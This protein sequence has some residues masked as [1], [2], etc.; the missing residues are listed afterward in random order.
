MLAQIKLSCGIARNAW[1]KKHPFLL[2]LKPTARCNLRCKSCNRWQ[3]D[4]SIHEELS[5][6]AIQEILAKFKKAGF[7]VFTLWGGEPTLR[8]D[9]PE[10]LAAAKQSGYRTSMCTNCYLLPQK[11]DVI[12]PHLDV[13]LCSLD[14]YG[15][16]HD[17]FRGVHGL[18]ERVVTSIETATKFYPRCYIKIWASVHKKNLDDIAKLAILAKELK[19]NIEYFPISLIQGYNE[20]LVPD[21]EDLNRAFGE[22]LRLKKHGFPV[23]NPYRALN[24]FR[25][26]KPFQCNFPKIAL[27]MDHTGKTYTC[28]NPAGTPMHCWGTYLD[29]DPE[30]VFESVDFKNVIA[31]LKNCNTCSLPC[32]LELSGN[33]SCRL[34]SLFFDFQRW[35]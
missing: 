26:A 24:I 18:F 23:R 12:L 33:L 1:I 11:V 25:N 8:K 5:L 9:L 20:N 22:I 15:K 29:F 32:M 16:T 17:D 4:S 30:R 34:L 2:Y 35:R 7:A 28:E 6:E 10:I 13:L 31:S 21:R 19:V 27:F 3:E 14:G